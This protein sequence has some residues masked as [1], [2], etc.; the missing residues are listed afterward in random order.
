MEQ[1]ARFRLRNFRITR[2]LIEINDGDNIGRL[3]VDF[4]ISGAEDKTNKL[5]A[6]KMDVLIHDEYKNLD[7]IVNSLGDY[8]YEIGCT[9]NELTSYFYKNA[10]AILFPYVRAYISSL[11][12]QSGIKPVTLPTLNLTQE[13]NKLDANAK[14]KEEN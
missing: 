11:T 7:I 8:E 6:L 3:S 13:G 12:C 9:E 2:S 10:P 4:K 14:I 5:Y 1:I